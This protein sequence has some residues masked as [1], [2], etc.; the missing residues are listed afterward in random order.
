MNL[1]ELRDEIHYLFNPEPDDDGTMFRELPHPKLRSSTNFDFS[2]LET[3][4]WEGSSIHEHTWHC[5]DN[6]ERIHTL[7]RNSDVPVRLFDAAL[8]IFADSI[9]A[10][11]NSDNGKRE[12]RYCPSVI[13]TFW[14][15]FETFIR[16]SS[17]L[18]VVTSKHISSE[19]TNFLQEREP[20]VDKKGDIVYR[21]KYQ[22]PLD[23][24]AVLLKYGYEFNVE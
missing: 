2:Y 4:A 8:H 22:A 7:T 9:I 6:E 19:I 23:R 3:F 14:S 5:P 21:S 24:Y 13:L 18:L 17:E 10:Y 12:L 20:Y 1:E 11:H 15:G 16:Y